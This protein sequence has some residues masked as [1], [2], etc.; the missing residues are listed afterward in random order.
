MG[1][2][3]KYTNRYQQY[4]MLYLCIYTL[5]GSIQNIH[6]QQQYYQVT[7]CILGMASG[8]V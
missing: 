8:S 7:T 5:L 2:F 3:K 6:Q 4:L 1:T